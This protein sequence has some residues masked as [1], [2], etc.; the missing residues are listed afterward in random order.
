[1]SVVLDLPYA[2]C[3]WISAAVA[4]FYTL[5]GGFYSVVYTDVIQLILIFFSLVESFPSS[6]SLTS[7]NSNET[8]DLKSCE[9]V[10]CPCSGCVFPLF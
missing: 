7:I 3:I 9:C 5:L 4:V 10:I 8:E 6:Q 2:V 1:M